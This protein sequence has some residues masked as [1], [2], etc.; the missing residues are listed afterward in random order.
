MASLLR[1]IRVKLSDVSDLRKAPLHRRSC[2]IYIVEFPKSGVTWL[3]QL[4]ANAHLVHIG[5]AQRAT[6]SSIKTFIPEL[7]GVDKVNQATQFG[8]TG[9]AF[10]K[11]HDDFNRYFSTVI[12]LVRHPVSVMRSYRKYR[13]GHGMSEISLEEFCEHPLYGIEA[14][15][16]NVRS[17][18][19][20]KNNSHN[21]TLS[22]IRYEDLIDGTAEALQALSDQF[23]WALTSATIN[24]AV[25][26]SSR[27]VM[28]EQEGVFRE[29]NPA[30]TLEFVGKG[31]AEVNP[32]LVIK[33]QE[34]CA[35]ELR[36]AGYL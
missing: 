10:Y 8:P 5:A 27:E 32:N 6:F 2:D 16:H 36:L 18:L 24:E 7:S 25:L 14:W 11:S 19:A 34:L 28:R 4:L 23:G 12:Y 30:H 21:R 1:R 15:R 3:T 9:P 17:W 26:A 20:H 29:R 22:L 31:N 13:L 33:I 35:D